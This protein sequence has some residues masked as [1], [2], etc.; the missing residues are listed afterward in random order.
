MGR[1]RNALIGAIIE[2]AFGIG[3][4]EWGTA[5]LTAKA[6]IAVRVVAAIIGLVIIA[7][8]VRLRRAY[9]GP[10]EPSMF[11]SRGYRLVV[12]AEVG[13]LVVGSV[14]LIV[15]GQAEYQIAWVAFVVGVHFVGFGKLFAARYYVL[16]GALVVAALA[17]VVIG[18]T[19]GGIA[20]TE[21]VTGFAAG[22]SMFLAAAQVLARR[23]PELA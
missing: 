20:L 10:E 9:S 4:I 19:G 17:G 22:V 15:S 7:R 11:A 16:G 18:L 13:A 1:T 3:W 21:A 8:S 12:A 23:Q 6:W 14:V 2:G 5:N